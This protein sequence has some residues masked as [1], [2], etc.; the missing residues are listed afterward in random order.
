MQP[1]DKLMRAPIRRRSGWCG[2][3]TTTSTS[4]SITVLQMRA[5]FE[6][7]GC[8]VSVAAAPYCVSLDLSHLFYGTAAAAENKQAAAAAVVAAASH[9]VAPAEGAF[10]KLPS[11]SPSPSS[12]DEVKEQE[13]EH[14]G[15][16]AAA[17]AEL[18]RKAN[19][20]SGSEE[21]EEEKPRPVTSGETLLEFLGE[22][23]CL[24]FLSC[25]AGGL[26]FQDDFYAGVSDE[27]IRVTCD[28]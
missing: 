26:G 4:T 13:E 8:R 18:T 25:F 3:S 27:A 11:R 28:V 9:T 22:L 24:C 10:I 16:D 15:L 6:H 12:D 1:M 23:L 20:S 21:E 7:H 5:L 14:W 2:C 17:A 19:S